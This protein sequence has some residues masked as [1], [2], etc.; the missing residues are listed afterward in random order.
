MK[1][2]LLVAWLFAGVLIANEHGPSLDGIQSLDV[3]SDGSRLHLLLGEATST[4]PVPVLRHLVS[5]DGGTTWSEPVLIDTR[6]TPPSGMRRGMDAQIAASGAHVVI[7]WPTA[8]TDAWGGGPM[9]TALS[10]DGG[11]TWTTG[12]NPADDGSTEGHNFFDIAADGKGAFHLAWLDTRSGKRGLRSALSQDHG[13]SWSQNRTVDDETCECCWNTI[14]TSPGGGAWVIYR[15]KSPRDMAVAAINIENAKPV[16]VGQ[17]QWEFL[18]CPHVGA[19]LSLGPDQCLH[20]V[21][22][23]GKDD[24]TGVYYLRSDAQHR[25][26]SQPQR[27]AGGPARN[28]DC[29]V[30]ADGTIAVVWNVMSDAGLQIQTSLSHDGGKQWTPAKAISQTA[31]ATHPRIVPIPHGFRVFW[32]AEL[33]HQSIWQSVSIQ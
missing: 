13:A 16:S 32:T 1:T 28:P 14:A 33:N 25:S 7:V 30:N 18:G 24:Q 11:K 22:W 20:A 4:A 3:S 31:S 23:S 6:M 27:L 9:A 21:V 12:P 19:G 10:S 5:T 2:T 26:W 29:A 15:D 8:G 17:F